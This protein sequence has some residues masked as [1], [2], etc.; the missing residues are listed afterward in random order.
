[1]SETKFPIGVLY[2]MRLSDKEGGR[3]N[4]YVNLPEFVPILQSRITGVESAGHRV[5]PRDG[6]IR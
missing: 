1:M 2:N 5:V 6:V 4:V 3:V